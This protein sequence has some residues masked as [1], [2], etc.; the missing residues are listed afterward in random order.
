M[1]EQDII[2]IFQRKQC[3]EAEF[4]IIRDCSDELHD[5]DHTCQALNY[6]MLKRRLL[7]IEHWLSFLSPEECTVVERHLIQ[8]QPWAHIAAQLERERGDETSFDERTL[9]RQQAK[10]ISKICNFMWNC[11]AESLDFLIDSKNDA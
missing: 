4:A 3:Y 2:R 7:L 11:F 6:A 1:T 10:A 5:F 9:Q 8:S